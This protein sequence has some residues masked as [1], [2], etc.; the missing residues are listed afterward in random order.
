MERKVYNV[1]SL[2]EAR[3]LAANDFAEFKPEQV[4]FTILL[5]KKDMLGNVKLMV[6]ALAGADVDGATK[7]REYLQT[8]L[9]DNGADGTVDKRIQNDIIQ[10]DI[11]AGHFNGYLIGKNARTLMALQVLASAVVNHGLDREHEQTVLVDVGGYKAR[12]Q[13]IIE[14]MAV[15]EARKVVATGTECTMEYL[16]AYER[17]IV[18]AKLAKWEEI[19]TFSVGKEP[20]RF[21]HIAL[22]KAGAARPAALD[23]EDENDEPILPVEEAEES[24]ESSPADEKTSEK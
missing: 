20:Q 22:K 7:G 9:H 23:D 12:R 4:T 15:D 13:R 5:E 16:N 3:A 17:K 11:D 19:E 1:K 14:R 21:L 24:T 18:H 6:E 2:E 10:Y 8:I